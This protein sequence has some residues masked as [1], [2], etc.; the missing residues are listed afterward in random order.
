MRLLTAFAITLF[1]SFAAFAEKDGKESIVKLKKLEDSKIQLIYRSSPE[2]MVMVKFY[3][4]NNSLVHTDKIQTKKA[5]SKA[6]DL[7]NLEPGKYQV[8]VFGKNGEI[9]H[10]ELNLENKKVEPVVYSKLE[11]AD[12]NKYS[13]TV[14]ALLPSNMT[15][16][17]YEDN[18]LV[19]SEQLKNT[20]GFKK[21]YVFTNEYAH[22]KSNISFYVRSDDGFSKLLATK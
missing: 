21:T 2:G 14:N 16:D 9:D 22:S 5:F 6:Y 11:R 7:S 19:Y 3:D 20:K 12:M 8:G 18:I 1:I 15:V 10:L 13:L 17:I 4:Q